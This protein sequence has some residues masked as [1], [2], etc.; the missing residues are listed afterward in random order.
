MNI[1]PAQLFKAL[2]DTTRLRCLSLLV[3]EGELC[4]CELTEVMKLA[5][6]KVS[7]HLA[8]LRK[9]GIVTDRKQ[10]LWIYYRINE[11]LPKWMSKVIQ[12]AVRGISTEQ[13]YAADLA[14]LE[15][16]RNSANSACA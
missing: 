11:A 15:E 12:T 14:A 3:C 1:D 4:V 7:H 16:V 5:Q 13:P 10:G 6:P 2:S 8:A 9:T